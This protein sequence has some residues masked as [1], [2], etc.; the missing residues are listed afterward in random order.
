MAH[1]TFLL[2]VRTDAVYLEVDKSTEGTNEGIAFGAG[3]YCDGGD[4]R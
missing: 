4:E 1:S 3:D 2:C